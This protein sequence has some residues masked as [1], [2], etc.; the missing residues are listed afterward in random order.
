MKIEVEQRDID[1]AIPGDVGDCPVTRSAKR[2]TGNDDVI[3]YDEWGDWFLEIGGDRYAA[4]YDAGS[5]ARW[6]D[7]RELVSPAT[8]VFPDEPTENEED[9]DAEE[10]DENE[11]ENE[12]D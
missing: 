5:F 10:D 9:C 4:P 8:F 6:F 7:A 12:H 3:F 1:G 11:E 2:I